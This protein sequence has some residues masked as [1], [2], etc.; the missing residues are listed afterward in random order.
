M[1]RT[2]LF[3]EVKSWLE[4]GN[5]LFVSDDETVFRFRIN[6]DNGL[7]DVRVLC[8]DEPATLQVCCPVPVR[9]PQEKVAETGLLLHNLN[10]RLRIGSFQFHV[11]ERVVEFRLTMPIRP[12]GELAE[13]FGQTVGTI[14]AT[15]DEHVRTLALLAC[16]TP[17]ARKAVV[18][19]SPKAQTRDANSHL[20]AKRFELN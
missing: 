3:T 5:I 10:A 13:Q 12:E 14:V 1:N 2:E 8:E 17:D 6:G 9:I 20:H 19:L 11:E 7:F 4:A 18:K 16:S 15:M